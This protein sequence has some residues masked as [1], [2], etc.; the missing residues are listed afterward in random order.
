MKR[1]NL[2]ILVIFSLLLCLTG[3]RPKGILH[4]WEMRKLLVDLHKTDALLQINGLYNASSEDKGLYYAQVLEKHGVTQAEFDSSLVWYT[5]HPQLFD[6][7]YPKVLNDLKAE[8]ELFVAQ[9][10]DALHL[11]PEPA[12]EIPEQIEFT[13]ADLDSVKWIMMHGYPSS[14]Q[15]MPL[16]HDFENEFFPQIGVLRGGVVD[17]LQS[18]VDLP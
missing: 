13:Q 6:K 3:C 16:V 9:N 18:R 5:A 7:I 8:E 1:P 11:T 4:S 2:Y 10:K 14:W 12:N 17:T 15:P